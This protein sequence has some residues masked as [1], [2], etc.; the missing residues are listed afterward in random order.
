MTV[1]SGIKTFLVDHIFSRITSKV[2]ILVLSALCVFSILFHY[3]TREDA[4][5]ISKVVGA[6]VVPFQTG[7]NEVGSFL[8]RKNTERLDLAAALE[9]A[10]ALEKE[11]LELKM[12]LEDAKDIVLENEELRALLHA[13]ERF[14]GYE[15][16]E[17]KVIGCDGVNCFERFTI[18]KGAM[19]GVK[20]DMNVINADGLVGIVTDVGLNYAVVTSI[21]EDNTSVSAM[22]RYG[23]QNCIAAGDLSVSGSGRMQLMNALADFDP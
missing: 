22:T 10:D 8:F 17:A 1:F 2:V 16:Q 15:M 12:Q 14:S 4:V 6:V 20:K 9:K 18:N 13:K 21:I 3:F 5:P 11:N 19:D 23:H 7:A